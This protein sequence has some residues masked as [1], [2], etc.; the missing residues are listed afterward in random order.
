VLTFS[1]RRTLIALLSKGFSCFAAAD[2]VNVLCR[3]GEVDVR[4][5]EG[6]DERAFQ[7][8]RFSNL[9]E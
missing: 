2:A 6:E 7:L 3:L 1:R 5:S 9:R 8:R 4:V